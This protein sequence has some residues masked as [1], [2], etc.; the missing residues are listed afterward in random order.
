MWIMNFSSSLY[1]ACSS[2]SFIF[3]GGLLSFIVF[4]QAGYHTEM[5][6]LRTNTS[7]MLGVCVHV[8]V[9]LLT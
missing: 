9:L 2:H 6:P 8:L 4:K 3:I 7:D 5:I 1:S